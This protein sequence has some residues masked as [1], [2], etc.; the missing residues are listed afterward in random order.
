[1]AEKSPMI[2]KKIWGKEKQRCGDIAL[3]MPAQETSRLPHGQYGKTRR[4]GDDQVRGADEHAG[5]KE[6]RMTERVS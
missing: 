5:D 1:M 6:K 4:Q 2:K 3:C